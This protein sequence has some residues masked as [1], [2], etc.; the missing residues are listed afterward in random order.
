MPFP[1]AALKNSQQQQQKSGEQK[2]IEEFA[3]LQK[4]VD[5]TLR[6]LQ[7][8]L[9][10]AQGRLVA[11]GQ[12][13]S[14]GDV[15]DDLRNGDEVNFMD[16]GPSDALVVAPSVQSLKEATGRTGA[17][18]MAPLQVSAKL[19]SP[20]ST[21]LHNISQQGK[22]DGHVQELHLHPRVIELTNRISDIQ[23]FAISSQRQS[24]AFMSQVENLSVLSL[25]ATWRSVFR[26][27]CVPAVVS[28]HSTLRLV[29]DA[30]G[31]ALILVDSFVL[32]VTIA[33]DLPLEPTDPAGF[34]RVICF[35]ISLLFWTC[36]MPLN[37][38]TGYYASGVLHT[39]RTTIAWKYL[40]TWLPFDAGLIALD[41][42]MVQSLIDPENLNGHPLLSSI[43]VLRIFRGLRVFRALKL[44]RLSMVIEEASIAA[45]KQWVVLVM[46]I[47][48]TTF[49]MAICAH[50]LACF[51]FLLGRI[52]SEAGH[53]SWI[54]IANAQDVDGGTQ[55]LHSFIW[56]LSVPGPPPVHP[57]S[58]QERAYCI[59][60]IFSQI[61]II[62]SAVS[63]ISDTLGELRSAK[64]EQSRRRREIRTYLHSQEIPLELTV[65]VMKFVDYKL[66]HQSTA[67]LDESL[68]SPALNVEIHL[69]QRRHYL[70]PH[71]FFEFT[72]TLFPEVFA[73]ICMA[74]QHNMFGIGETVFAINQR[75]QS[76][77][78]TC[79]GTFS[80]SEDHTQY[81]E[82]GQ[83]LQQILFSCSKSAETVTQS[84]HMPT[85][86]HWFAEES[87]YSEFAVHG[88][89]LRAE[90]FC[91]VYTL[92]CET[93]C[94]I[95][96]GSPYCA[97]M[98]CE[99]ARDILKHINELRVRQNYD[100]LEY[101]QCAQ[102]AC[103]ETRAY[104]ERHP[105]QKTVLGNIVVTRPMEIGVSED[106]SHMYGHGISPKT[107][108]EE[109][110]KGTSP[111]HEIHEKLQAAFPELREATGSH[112]L[113]SPS[114]E[115]ERSVSACL[116]IVALLT[117][118]YENF[119][120]PQN[121]KDALRP[122]Q[123]TQLR[124][125][126]M[127]VAPTDGNSIH[128]LIVLLSIR[129]LGKSKRVTQQLGPRCQ[130]A[131][132]ALL[133]LMSE[134]T[135]VV[136]SVEW[137][138]EEEVNLLKETM[139]IHQQFNLAQMLQGENAP[140][141][142]LQLQDLIRKKGQKVFHFYMLFLVGFMSGLSG[143][144]GS[145]FLNAKNSES[146]I[147]GLSNLMRVLD[148]SPGTI[149]WNYMSKRGE[150]LSL[151]ATTSED[152]VLVRMACLARVRDETDFQRLRF[153]WELL[154]QSDRQVLADNFLAD[155][156]TQRATVLEFLPDCM[157]NAQ[158]NRHVGLTVLLDVLVDLLASLEGLTD[159]LPLMPD[160]NMRV[161]DLSEMAAFIQAVQNKHIFHTCVSRCRL[162]IADGRTYFKMTSA[163]WDRVSESETDA[164]QLAYCLSELLQRQKFVHEA[165]LRLECST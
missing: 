86:V 152:M 35:W 34:I 12:L 62:G 24:A 41:F 59:L 54:D 155:G 75:A 118:R 65:R 161:V 103:K 49:F 27:G 53:Q 8:R 1:Q 92:T 45:G 44:G 15:L 132:Q 84:S 9:Q 129:S 158:R 72:R 57:E 126:V 52:R 66:Q 47:F 148:S 111:A 138:D 48:H 21:V 101:E 122:E 33:W 125:I 89:T 58:A 141:S 131:E 149:Y 163:N 7:Q 165:V 110:L 162:H 154:A 139:Q 25:S 160:T 63:K 153:S 123:W 79:A 135:N 140:A 23:D 117:D 105:D 124:S 127:R 112:A 136:P 10:I 134:H 151:P 88:N 157:S 40:T 119:T 60:I 16:N 51:W 120:W 20:T 78:L 98:Y 102:V 70:T 4:D 32:P 43:R 137:L 94:H 81:D 6:Q 46:A 85:G 13:P 106:S 90:S 74:L 95:L 109:L 104:S 22:E 29:W 55:Y 39:S 56:V 130:R 146:V 28:P 144:R 36:D 18:V 67:I 164:T 61:A 30:L 83:M 143:G 69:H 82:H 11:I 14:P 113:L 80:L 100:H 17:R 19:R 142:I 37:F 76:M 77:Y 5:Q 147:L 50:F 64:A 26:H 159:E 145:K 99:Y 133:C 108:I 96:D 156:I 87:L 71:P 31:L 107:V 93:L 73:D 121:P 115:L 97:D 128:A 91:L 38:N 116:S 150:Q 3:A 2:V 114:S 68:I 42:I